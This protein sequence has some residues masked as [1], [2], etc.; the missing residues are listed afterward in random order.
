[1]IWPYLFTG[2]LTILLGW[3]VFRGTLL[4][5]ISVHATV[6]AMAVSSN[7]LIPSI[8]HPSAPT[9][10]VLFIAAVGFAVTGT[11]GALVGVRLR[12]GLGGRSGPATRHDPGKPSLALA[13]ALGYLAYIGVFVWKNRPILA[14]ALHGGLLERFYA[15]YSLYYSPTLWRLPFVDSL[16]LSAS[17][18][19]AYH[20]AQHRRIGVA[21]LLVAVDSAL[22]MALTGTRTITIIGIALYVAVRVLHRGSPSATPRKRVRFGLGVILSLLALVFGAVTVGRAA[23]GDR[24]IGVVGGTSGLGLLRLGGSIALLE[25]HVAGNEQ[26]NASGVGAFTLRP[27]VRP[28]CNLDALPEACEALYPRIQPWY[29]MPYL[30]N[31]STYLG[32]I[33]LDYGAVGILIFPAAFGWFAS[34]MFALADHANMLLTSI[35]AYAFACVALSYHF[36]LP[37]TGIFL[38]SV[39]ITV[40]GCVFDSVTRTFRRSVPEPATRKD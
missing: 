13:L 35:G 7:A 3:R 5:P 17:Y 32:D 33:W 36:F 30:W 15:L 16:L 2:A 40:G 9:W 6:F 26:R 1:M 14:S 10:S 28:F 29:P 21:T 22:A 8:S 19:T 34:L 11:L 4:N 12:D 37:Y 31:T 18:F 23:L 20:D 38:V 27:L 25:R 24:D 39:L